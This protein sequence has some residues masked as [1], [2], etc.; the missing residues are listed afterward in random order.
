MDSSWKSHN[1]ISSDERAWAT[2]Q[3][4]SV[5][6]YDKAAAEDSVHEANSEGTHQYL[7][8]SNEILN[9]I[10]ATPWLSYGP[11]TEQAQKLMKLW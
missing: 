10:I 2:K 7:Q 3:L 11:P 1:I 4:E 9:Q 8:Q 6:N 5:Q